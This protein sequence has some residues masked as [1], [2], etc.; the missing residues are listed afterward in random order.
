MPALGDVR[1]DCGGQDQGVFIRGKDGA[2]R[3]FGHPAGFDG[4]RPALRDPFQCAVPLKCPFM[5]M[6]TTTAFSSERR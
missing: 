6:R 4:E 1:G 3:L 2:A 5:N